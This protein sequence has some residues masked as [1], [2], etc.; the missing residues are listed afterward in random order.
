MRTLWSRPSMPNRPH[1]LG[2][3]CEARRTRDRMV[4]LTA[5]LGLAMAEVD[6][7]LLAARFLAQ[8]ALGQLSA[9]SDADRPRPQAWRSRD[10]HRRR[11]R[12]EHV[13]TGEGML[14]A[15]MKR[16]AR[17]RRNLGTARLPTRSLPPRSRQ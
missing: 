10:Q 1:R 6:G 14:R 3:S 12:D 5:L 15:T 11:Q 4:R 7:P 17:A 8:D 16:A 9:T 2:R 13:G